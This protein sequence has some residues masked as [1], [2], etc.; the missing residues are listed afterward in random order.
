MFFVITKIIK[1]G[2][3]GEEVKSVVKPEILKSEQYAII[4]EVNENESKSKLSESS[5]GSVEVESV[6]N[7]AVQ[8][9]LPS[10]IPKRFYPGDVVVQKVDAIVSSKEWQPFFGTVLK[11]APGSEMS[12]NPDKGSSGEFHVHWDYSNRIATAKASEVALV[13]RILLRGQRV[14]NAKGQIGTV[15]DYSVSATVQINGT[16]YI[17]E[18][19]PLQRLRPI[20]PF[21]RGQEVLHNGWVGVVTCI[22]RNVWFRMDGGSIFSVEATEK[23]GFTRADPFWGLG[24]ACPGMR[25]RL[26][27]TAL[28]TAKWI[29]SPHRF[30]SKWLPLHYFYGW[31]YSTIIRTDVLQLEVKWLQPSDMTNAAS[32]AVPMPNPIVNQDQLK[33]ILV[34]GTPS[35]ETVG[36]NSV[37]KLR[38]WSK[39]EI[40]NYDVWIAEFR[41]K[42][43]DGDDASTYT[44]IKPNADSQMKNLDGVTEKL[45]AVKI[46]LIS[47]TIDDG[48][49]PMGLVVSPTDKDGARGEKYGI[50]MESNDLAKSRSRKVN[51]RWIVNGNDD[52]IF[53]ESVFNIRPH[54]AYSLYQRGAIVFPRDPSTSE[55]PSGVVID[56]NINH[57]K[58]V[59][60]RSSNGVQ[61]EVFPHEVLA[62]HKRC[63]WSFFTRSWIIDDLVPPPY[64][65]EMEYD[66]IK[67]LVDVSEQKLNVLDIGN[68]NVEDPSNFATLWDEPSFELLGFAPETHRYYN[69]KSKS[70]GKGFAQKVEKELESLRD[71]FNV[72]EG[73]WIRCYENRLDLL[74]VLMV[75]PT[76]SPYE[77]GLFLFD[78]QLQADF[79]ASRPAV[80]YVSY[81][82]EVHPFL[83]FDGNVCVSAIPWDLP[84]GAEAPSSY[85]ALFLHKLQAII[86]TPTPFFSTIQK[87]PEESPE[88]TLIK[89]RLYNQGV[90]IRVLD[91]SWNMLQKPHAP[92]ERNIRNHF[93]SIVP[94]KLFAIEKLLN[95]PNTAEATEGD[96]DIPDYPLLPVPEGFSIAA[97]SRIE[98]FK[99][100][101]SGSHNLPTVQIVSLTDTTADTESHVVK[102]VGVEGSR[103]LT[104]I[105]EITEPSSTS[106]FGGKHSAISVHSDD[107]AEQP[108]SL[109]SLKNVKQGTNNNKNKKMVVV[110]TASSGELESE[111]DHEHLELK[112]SVK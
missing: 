100:L 54:K 41:K 20:S 94:E 3:D 4:T 105:A 53:E 36:I 64:Q 29:T 59:I 7:T 73:I 34:I 23:D 86:F 89:S 22:K 39:D 71:K 19:V 84:E 28:K 6:T 50:V 111:P 5:V 11:P 90:L 21:V 76:K 112:A 18:R 2:V 66:P 8:P 45:P 69:S 91:S 99:K 68:N 24:V 67:K 43:L 85:I 78:V 9:T 98:M 58:M 16:N 46:P 65:L 81:T 13:D 102:E 92:W 1:I 87:K 30:F 47:P 77:D 103:C 10:H 49:F 95:L 14:Q 17:V 70:F 61:D 44:T 27:T 62:L 82:L 15:V 88:R 93:A 37:R 33:Q 31:A 25:T 72:P 38:V 101:I 75:G 96:E 51:V 109:D 80:H 57:G 12:K 108:P 52:G 26:P 60:I 79:P 32:Q 42:F 35:T 40:S 74:S 55:F 107:A 106:T 83:S 97:Q 56:V 48:E 104:P 110:T 63:H